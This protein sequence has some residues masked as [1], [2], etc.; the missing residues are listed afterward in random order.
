MTGRNYLFRNGTTD[1]AMVLPYGASKSEKTAAM[2]LRTY[3][4][5]ISGTRLKL[6]RK[7]PQRGKF[8]FIGHNKSVADEKPKADDETYHYITKD[9]NLYIW[10]GSLRGTMYGV[11]SFL[12][13]VM[14][15]RWYTA[16]YTKIPKRKVFVMPNLRHSESP[17]LRGRFNCAYTPIHNLTWCAHNKMNEHFTAL[18]NKYGGT[19]AIYGGHSFFYLV[20]PETYFASHPEYYSWRCGRRTCDNSQL[21]LSNPEVLPIVTNNVLKIIQENPGYWAY[22]VSQCDNTN[23]CECYSCTKI[24]NKYGGQSGLLLWFVNQV[25]EEVEKFFPEKKIS[26]MAYLYSRKSPTGIKP[27][28]NVV[29]RLCNIEC[30]FSHPLTSSQCERNMAFMQDL[31]DWSKLTTNLYAWDYVVN[32]FNYLSPFPDFNVLP[33]NIRTFIKYGVTTLLEE[34]AYDARWGAFSEMRTWVIAKLLWNPHQDVNKLV[35]QFCYDY[36]GNAAPKIYEFYQMTQRTPSDGHMIFHFNY[37][38]Q[39]YDKVFIDQAIDVLEDAQDAVE[40]DEVMEKRVNRVLAQAYY[41]YVSR[42]TKLAKF[43]WTYYKLMNI[44]KKDPTIIKEGGGD[45]DEHLKRQCYTWH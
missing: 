35:R 43:T 11:F 27:R 41:L 24:A 29:I 34:G 38:R 15:V 26:T 42:H 13:N 23:F 36:Y 16:K 44:L 21:C 37:E 1:Y 2:E 20:P 5:K 7:E 30:C 45:F 4:Q 3:L 39:F 10:G 28:D 31:K 14:G 22:C 17:Q 25:A 18:D 33:E 19:S 9:G 12:E 8:I 40:G 6:L 32:F